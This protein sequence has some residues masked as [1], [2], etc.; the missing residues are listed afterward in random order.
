M[1][2]YRP[3]LVTVSAGFLM[4]ASPT[5]ATDSV[6]ASAA[7]K[8]PQA[9]DSEDSALGGGVWDFIEEYF[10]SRCDPDCESEVSN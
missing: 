3:L 6:E 5:F 8:A 10:W 4:F 2:N 1:I 9:S 7:V